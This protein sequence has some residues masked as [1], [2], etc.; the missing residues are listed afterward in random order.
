MRICKQCQSLVSTSSLA[1]KGLDKLASSFGLFWTGIPLFLFPVAHHLASVWS[2]SIIYYISRSSF[3]LVIFTRVRWRQQFLIN[4]TICHS[5]KHCIF[6]TYSHF[7]SAPTLVQ[8]T[9]PFALTLLFLYRSGFNPATG[10][11]T[12]TL[13][14][15]HPSR[16]P[17][18]GIG[19]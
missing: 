2:S 1:D 4:L 15:L 16:R 18:R 8:F 7:L 12:A 17:H 14:R 6:C 19:Q 13:L 9:S 11:P 3:E 10:S 5:P